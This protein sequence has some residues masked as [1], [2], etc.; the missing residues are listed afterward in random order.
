M[1][2][3]ELKAQIQDAKEEL[4]SGWGQA[5]HQK[6]HTLYDKG[7]EKLLKDRDRQEQVTQT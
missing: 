7:I 2:S 6:R 4:S 1:T 5:F 3:A